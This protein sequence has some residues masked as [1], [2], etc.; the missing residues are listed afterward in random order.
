MEAAS[1]L[2]ANHRKAWSLEKIASDLIPS[3]LREAFCSVAQNPEALK[4]K[5]MLSKEL[6]RDRINYHVFQ[7]ETGVWVSSPFSEVGNTVKLRRE[8]GKRTLTAHGVVLAEKVQRDA[9][10][11]RSD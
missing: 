2:M 5:F 11:P 10:R 6:L 1:A 3:R 8:G 9:K 4:D 7:L